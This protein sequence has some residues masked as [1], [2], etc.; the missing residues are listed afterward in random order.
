MRS[1]WVCCQSTSVRPGYFRH[2]ESPIE[3][4]RRRRQLRFGPKVLSTLEQA[5]SSPLTTRTLEHHHRQGRRRRETEPLRLTEQERER[6]QTTDP[7]QLCPTVAS[8]VMPRAAVNSQGD[9]MFIVN[10]GSDQPQFQ[11]LVRSE[12]CM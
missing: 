11:Q 5:K 12:V 1:V 9:W 3:V 6:R 7:D 8:F 4:E 10:M 2:S